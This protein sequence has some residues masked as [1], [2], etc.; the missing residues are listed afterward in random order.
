MAIIIEGFDNSG[1]STLAES[2][3]LEVL[4]PG[5]RP[6]SVVAEMACI[7]H[8]LA[9]A[10]KPVV[11]DRVT[12]ISSPAY[13]GNRPFHRLYKR[14][15]LQLVA[16]PHCVIIYCRPPIE[17]ILDFST[18]KAKAYDTR[19]S[20]MTLRRKARSIVGN[21]DG[22]MMHVPHLRYDYTNPDR[23]VVQLAYDA[24]HSLEAWKTWLS[25]TTE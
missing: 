15:A 14:H 16:T 24:Q 25:I 12:C 17:T 23:K 10:S 20:E 5:P 7:Q 9:N 18:H 4:H 19:D 21:Y 13:A 11:M 2:F 1:K 3:G 22:I 8:Q 6:E